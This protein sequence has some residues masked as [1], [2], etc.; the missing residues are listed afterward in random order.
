M[1]FEKGLDERSVA[2][3]YSKLRLLR[4][5]SEYVKST[6][7]S[8]NGRTPVSGTAREGSTPSTPAN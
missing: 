3:Y 1:I 7:V 4:R 5:G 8:S 2:Y 6:G